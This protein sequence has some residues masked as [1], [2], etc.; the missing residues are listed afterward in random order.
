MPALHAAPRSPLL[1]LALRRC[2]RPARLHAK[3]QA[4]PRCAASRRQRARTGRLRRARRRDALRRRGR[5]A[6][7]ASMPTW[8]RESLAR[9]RFVPSGGAADHAA[10]GRHGEELGAPTAPASSSRCASAPGSRSG[11]RTNAGCSCA[12]ERYGVPPSI[13]VGIVGVET[14]YGRQ[15]GSFRVLDALA[16]LAFDFPT[17]RRDRSAFFRDELESFLLLCRSEGARPDRSRWAATPARWACRSSCPRSVLTVRASTSTATATSTCMRSAA[18]VIGSVA[19]YLAAVRLGA[20]HADALR[21]GRAGRGARPRAAAGARHPA[22]LQPRRVRRTRRRARRAPAA[23]GT[24]SWPWW[25]C[26]TATQRR[27]TWPAPANFYAITRYNWSSYYA[28]AV[29]ELGEAVRRQRR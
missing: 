28:M 18:D 12:E 3:T 15:T 14:I 2:P 13:V 7:A 24:A 29:I 23:P 25:N 22:E 26:R 21:R 5:R 6:P 27:A 17:G 16:T 10:A 9:A 19:H 1:S 20:R 4:A 11:A 8:V